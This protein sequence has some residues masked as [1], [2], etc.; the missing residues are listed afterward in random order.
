MKIN[1]P[2]ANGESFLDDYIRFINDFRISTDYLFF[3]LINHL[4]VETEISDGKPVII[5]SAH[6]P[7]IHPDVEEIRKRY[8]KRRFNIEMRP[9]EKDENTQIYDSISKGLKSCLK[10]SDYSILEILDLIYY[11]DMHDQDI[12]KIKLPKTVAWV[13]GEKAKK[14]YNH[15]IPKTLVKMIENSKDMPLKT[16]SK[17]AP[18][19]QMIKKYKN[20]FDIYAGLYNQ[21]KYNVDMEL[22]KLYDTFLEKGERTIRSTNIFMLLDDLIRIGEEEYGKQPLETK[23]KPG[24]E[25]HYLEQWC[26]DL[27]RVYSDLIKGGMEFRGYLRQQRGVGTFFLHPHEQEK[28]PELDILLKRIYEK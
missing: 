22:L 6:F 20:L 1:N 13:V 5:K 27:N 2:F 7:S 12:T 28:Y 17:A 24:F 14:R 3:K 8:G 26:T 16:E 9:D 18:R 23:F 15:T 10:A 21:W 19:F 11:L 25:S 4:I